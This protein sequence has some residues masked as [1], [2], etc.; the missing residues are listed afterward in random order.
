M[1]HDATNWRETGWLIESHKLPLYGV[2][3]NYCNV[4]HRD[5][6]ATTGSSK[7]I[8]YRCLP[9][10]S[11]KKV[12][13]IQDADDKE[14]FYV[15]RWSIDVRTGSPLLLL[16]GKN[17]LLQVFDF[18]TGQ[19]VT[20]F[21]GHGHS[22]NDI[23]VHPTKPHLV[24][25]ASKDHCLR[26]W[27]LHSRTC[28]LV[29][30]GDGGHRSEVLCADWRLGTKSNASTATGT[31]HDDL[32]LVSGGMDNRVKIWN[33]TPF[34][35]FI[36]ESNNWDLNSGVSF[37]AR[38]VEFPLHNYQG[39][40]WNYVDCIKW[41]GPALVSKSVSNTIICWLPND[42]PRGISDD[43]STFEVGKSIPGKQQRRRKEGD[44][45]PGQEEG[46]AR[47]VATLRLEGTKDVWWM[48]FSLDF[49]G[50]ILAQGTS[51]GAVLVYRMHPL[52]EQ[53]V[54]KLKPRRAGKNEEGSR[55]LVRQT[56]VSFDGKTIVSCHED[57]SLTRYDAVEKG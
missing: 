49:R 33:L 40:H 52:Q 2:A 54:A 37:P 6:F 13:V 46:E 42:E 41:F 8:V 10:G 30:E 25:T 22:I 45:P 18:G 11:I 32:M 19:L 39:I 24:V 21:E 29:F 44:A 50:N 57:G 53:Y 47:A 20:S 3:F 28:I 35:D 5:L 27:N 31:P 34:R 55:L 12:H 15:C 56:A 7:A 26:L 17:A 9:D 14:E 43:K 48:R 16:A 36:E 51:R 4:E 1:G 38:N 23:A